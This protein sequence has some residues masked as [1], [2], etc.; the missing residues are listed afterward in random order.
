MKRATVAMPDVASRTTDP[1]GPPAS[2]S[3]AT[4]VAL[5][6]GLPQ[7]AQELA[8]TRML[9]Q[10]R[11]WL[12]RA[13]EATNP[14]REVAEFKAFIATV[15]EAAKQKKLSED[16]QLDA[17][18]MV[19]RSERALGVAIRKGQEAG[20]VARRGQGG[21]T[22]IPPG[23]TQ[24][25]SD[26]GMSLPTDFAKESELSGNGGGIY[27]VTDGVSDEQ[28]E[29]ALSEAKEER[30]L[31]RANVVRK[32]TQM[33]SFRE[34]QETKWEKVELL[35]NS[36]LTSPQIASEVGMSEAG[37][38]DGARKRGIEFPADRIVGKTRRIDPLEVIEQTV[39][40]LEVTE[41]SLVLADLSEVTAEQ[42]AEWLSRIEKPLRSLKQFQ[43]KLKGISS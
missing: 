43:T 26:R 16:I 33:Q 20:E 39:L 8:I 7:E 40:S 37:L 27:A 15:A 25:R 30:N 19:R 4:D 35:A 14:A 2:P 23:A 3:A 34:K 21:G 10:S 22:E 32:V 41:S 24:P 17:V 29:S 42:A 1:F 6:D 9:D 13:L 31:S 12:D 28:F 36:G 11:Q 5:L 38:R 18:E